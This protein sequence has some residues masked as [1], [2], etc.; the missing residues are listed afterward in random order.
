M[1]RAIV[2]EEVL[3]RVLVVDLHQLVVL[4]AYENLR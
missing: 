3:A 4:D 1:V 2:R